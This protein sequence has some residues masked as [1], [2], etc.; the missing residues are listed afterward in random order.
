M[1]GALALTETTD[2]QHN[3]SAS[4]PLR[5]LTAVLVALFALDNVLLLRL[6]GSPPLLVTALALIVPS[7]LAIITYRLMP[8][9]CRIGLP[10]I[11]TCL[12]IAAILLMLGGEGRLFYA[13]PDWQVRDAVLADMGNHRW[14]FDYW[15]DGRSQ[16]LRAPVGMYLV[17]ALFGGAS[18]FGRDWILL[19][20]N[21]L[22]LGLL[23]A[24][25]TALFESR[26]TRLIALLVFVAFS[27]LDVLG[28]LLVQLLN[29]ETRWDH[30][31]DWADGYQY[32][33]HITQLFWVPQHAIAG[34]TAALAY[35]LWQRKLAPIGLFAA[36]LPLV[37]LWSPLVLFGALPFALF[38]G[39]RTLSTHAWSW[40]DVLWCGI[41][42]LLAIPA[43]LYLSTGAAEVGGGLNPPKAIVYVLLLLLEVVPF[44]LPVL[45]DC[46][47]RIDRPTILIAGACLFLM[48]SW[49]IGMFNDFQMR[50]SIMPLAVLA[51]AFADWAGRIDHR[52]TKIICRVIVA[53]GAVTGGIEIANALRLSPSPVP[54]CSVVGVWDRQ[55]GRSAPYSSYFAD[56][57]AFRFRPHPV[58]RVSTANLAQCW[59]HP[60]R[61][62]IGSTVSQQA[63]P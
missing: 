61:M 42:I 12:A 41:A 7:T 25:G 44:L 35:L 4:L 60:W 55:I 59:D 18:Q 5:M 15:L 36:I 10:T 34:W 6:L 46:D 50:A 48:P 32:S 47:N 43:L 54:H 62:P 31:E 9:A 53:L 30:I 38:A 16:M 13:P 3:I 58:D 27:G 33:S 8:G 39:C 49:T 14:P 51:L 21:S 1:T 19:A 63:R 28:N 29:G 24:Q 17:P 26:R 2:I 22:V 37:A 45:R 40:R 23:L 52:H 57:D 20:Q 56:R 11:L